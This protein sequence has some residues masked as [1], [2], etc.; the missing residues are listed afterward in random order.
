MS[1]C[2]V[3]VSRIAI[4][5][6]SDDERR[7][8]LKTFIAIIHF[9]TIFRHSNGIQKNINHTKGRFAASKHSSGKLAERRERPQTFAAIST[10]PF[11]KSNAMCSSR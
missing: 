7:G 1:T 6:T 10:A 8:K 11:K 5:K 3:V 2:I 4:R 9:E